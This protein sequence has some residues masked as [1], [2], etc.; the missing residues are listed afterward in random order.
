M[1][2]LG[3]GHVYMYKA[4]LFELQQ[5]DLGSA[6]MF[7]NFRIQVAEPATARAELTIVYIMHTCIFSFHNGLEHVLF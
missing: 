7:L 4:S 6:W 2:R 5:T 1:S 3:D